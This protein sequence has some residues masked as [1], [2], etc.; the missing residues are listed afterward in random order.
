[1]VDTGKMSVL[2]VF[3]DQHADTEMFPSGP[4]TLNG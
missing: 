2:F 3:V 4:A 1:L